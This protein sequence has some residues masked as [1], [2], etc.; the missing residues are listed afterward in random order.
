MN[1]KINNHEFELIKITLKVLGKFSK[2]DELKIIETENCFEVM[3]VCKDE[4]FMTKTLISK[5]S[6]RVKE[7]TCFKVGGTEIKLK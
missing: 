4:F 2:F 6:W 3:T 5:F 1:F 7:S